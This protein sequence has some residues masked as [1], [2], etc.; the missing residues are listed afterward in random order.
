M[1]NS[2]KQESTM[3]LVKHYLKIND[4][5]S[6]KKVAWKMQSSERKEISKLVSRFIPPPDETCPKCNSKIS[7]VFRFHAFEWRKSGCKVCQYNQEKQNINDKCDETLLSRGVSIRYLKASL[8]DFPIDYSEDFKNKKSIFMYGPRG[9]GKTHLMAAMMR[10]EVLNLEP[11]KGWDEDDDIYY[12][13]PNACDFPIFI[14]VPELMLKLRETFNKKH[15]DSQTESE[16]LERY[17]EAKVLYLDDLGTEKAS[18]WATQT[19]YLLID[20]RYSEIKRTI[21]SSNLNLNQI[22]ERIDDRISS[23]I[24]GMCEIIQMTGGDRRLN[25]K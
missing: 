16:I 23:R 12:F 6:A 7:Y 20:R 18:D 9:T 5:V 8:K 13:E 10:Y 21:I 15:S 22:A 25:K 19:L 11:I 4:L 1:Q 24:A 14:S 3:D 17:S 2:Q